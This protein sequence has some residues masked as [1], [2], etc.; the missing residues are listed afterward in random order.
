M[1]VK[2]NTNITVEK[3]MMVKMIA[4]ITVKNHD[5]DVQILL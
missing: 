4:N 2:M 3:I 5:G 1:M